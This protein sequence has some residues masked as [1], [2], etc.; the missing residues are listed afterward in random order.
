MIKTLKFFN[1]LM[2]ISLAFTLSLHA[3]DVLYSRSQ[4]YTES[5]MEK[6]YKIRRGDTLYRIIRSK[7]KTVN[8]IRSVAERIVKNNPKSFPTGNKNLMLSGTHLR[9]I[10][11][12]TDQNRM[13][14][15]NE[16]FFIK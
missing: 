1:I 2:I 6:K 9:L 14:N 10:M 3:Q 7:L 13:R 11:N 4:G 8:D 15:R 5:S 12:E 16:I